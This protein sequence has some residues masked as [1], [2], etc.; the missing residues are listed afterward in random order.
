MSDQIVHE[1]IRAELE[2]HL[3]PE[4]DPASR[5]RLALLVSGMI[6]AASACPARIAAA[7]HKLG[8]RQATAASLERQIRRLENDPEIAATLCVHPLAR[9]HLRWGRPRQLLLVMDGTSQDDRVVML[10]A[11]VWYRGRA[12]PLAWACWP[13]NT[14]L[15]GAR[16]WE[17]VKAVLAEVAGLLP[18][19]VPVIWL[20]D[21]AFGTPAFTDQIEAR[22]WHWVVRV[23]G[24]TRYQ[25]QAGRL[26]P[27]QSLVTRPGQRKKGRGWVFKKQGWRQAS[28][29]VHCGRRHKTA[30]MLVS[31]TRE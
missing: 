5:E 18:L 2:R 27:I 9:A 25:D 20:A 17:R 8:L 6:E 29:V 30:L 3:A 11:A 19:G 26:Q 24:Q 7:V 14:P 21:R 13:A 16:F 10:T 22:G 12:L 4:V 15:V 1:E 31:D 28:V 23:Q